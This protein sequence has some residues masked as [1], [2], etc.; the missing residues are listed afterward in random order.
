MRFAKTQ[1]LN[2]FFFLFLAIVFRIVYNMNSVVYAKK[3]VV[4][5][6]E[7]NTFVYICI[8]FRMQLLLT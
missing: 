7:R 3:I 5:R 6:Y 4:L 8:L 1:A 2:Y